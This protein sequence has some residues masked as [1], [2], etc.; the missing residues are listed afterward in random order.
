[1]GEELMAYDS[2]FCQPRFSTSH[3]I[4]PIL[5]VP[6]KKFTNNPTSIK[7]PVRDTI[8][9]EAVKLPFGM[10]QCIVT[11]LIIAWLIIKWGLK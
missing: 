1:V 4:L 9:Q 5:L 2:G 7:T 6:A 11:A 8:I 10:V 3:L